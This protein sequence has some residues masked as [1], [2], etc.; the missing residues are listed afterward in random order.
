[1][2]QVTATLNPG[3]DRMGFYIIKTF[4]SVHWCFI[5]ILV[6]VGSPVAIADN[7]SM[8]YIKVEVTNISYV[9]DDNYTI[10]IILHNE[11]DQDYLITNF[12][13]KF[14]TQTEI[15]GQ[16]KLLDSTSGNDFIMN[17]YPY[18]SAED[19][20]S[21]S[22]VVNIPLTIPDLYFN[23]YGDINIK[24]IVSLEYS[25]NNRSDK[26]NNSVESSYWITPRTNK[27]VLREGM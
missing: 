25:E 17:E 11:S 16:W 8:H 4:L 7:S 2:I 14:Y 13:R 18:L 26:Y 27:W 5:I 3:P 15:L 12:E 24:L 9:G 22:T 19:N 1:M 23:A 10:E 6:I 20:K 21:I